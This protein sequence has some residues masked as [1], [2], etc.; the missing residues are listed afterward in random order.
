MITGEKPVRE[1]EGQ[2]E[3]ETKFLLANMS[4]LVPNCARRCLLNLSYTP[5]KKE[6]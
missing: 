2:G 6:K 1:R 4:A 5:D 3:Y